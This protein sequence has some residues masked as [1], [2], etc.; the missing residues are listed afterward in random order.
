MQDEKEARARMVEVRSEMLRKEKEEE[1]RE[2]DLMLENIHKE[3]KKEHK[4]IMVERAETK[5]KFDKLLIENKK[6]TPGYTITRE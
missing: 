2:E 4:R 3:I 1:K 6:K 5:A